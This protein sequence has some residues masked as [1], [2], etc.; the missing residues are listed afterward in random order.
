MGVALALAGERIRRARLAVFDNLP[1]PLFSPGGEKC[2]LGKGPSKHPPRRR[3]HPLS[4]NY[5]PMLRRRAVSIRFHHSSI[6]SG[7]KPCVLR[8]T[9][10]RFATNTMRSPRIGL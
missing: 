4:A 10:K 1:S 3:V 8:V 9:G 7:S 2:G 6:S 5:W